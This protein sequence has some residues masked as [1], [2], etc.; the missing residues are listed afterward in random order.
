M[1]IGVSPCELHL[2]LLL[3][4]TYTFA[5]YINIR[6]AI[7]H[8]QFLFCAFLRHALIQND[9]QMTQLQR[10]KDMNLGVYLLNGDNKDG[11]H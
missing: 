7:G 1:L 4:E 10:V 6:H 11:G 8:F 5:Q 9:S 2:V 3:D